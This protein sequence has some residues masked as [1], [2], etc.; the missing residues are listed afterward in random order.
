M[1]FPQIKF[2]QVNQMRI[3]RVNFLLEKIFEKSL[4]EMQAPKTHQFWST[5]GQGILSHR[6]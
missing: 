5:Q 3:G 6:F 1:N 2:D 4:L